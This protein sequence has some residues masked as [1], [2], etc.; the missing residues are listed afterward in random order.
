MKLV[1]TG[2]ISHFDDG[3]LPS[4]GNNSMRTPTTSGIFS[5]SIVYL[6]SINCISLGLGILSRETW[7]A[8]NVTNVFK[9]FN[10]IYHTNFLKSI[11]NIHPLNFHIHSFRK[12]RYPTLSAPFFTLQHSICST[13]SKENIQTNLRKNRKTQLQIKNKCSTCQHISPTQRSLRLPYPIIS[14]VATRFLST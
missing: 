3:S 2:H 11:N 12:N 8:D 1:P 14:H 13:S 7:V 10:M 4:L 9:K 5:V 6:L